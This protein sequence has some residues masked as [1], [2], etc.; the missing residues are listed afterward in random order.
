MKIM[1][2]KNFGIFIV[3]EAR[4]TSKRLKR[5]HLYKFQGVTLIKLLV[6]KL[7]KVKKIN[8]IILATTK[9]KIENVLIKDLENEKIKIF[10]GSET[11]VLQRVIN[12]GKKFKA[13]A[14]CRI[15]GDCPLIDI[16]FVQELV[17]VYI[18]EKTNGIEFISNSK[19][20]PIGQG[21]SI[22]KLQTLEKIYKQTNLARHKEFITSYIWENKKNFQQL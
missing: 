12:A 10:R 3:I 16:R 13:E 8:G 22:V 7:K 19:G 11:N 5:K 15:T 18:K 14:I 17:D 20:L 4:S 2:K 9:N 1:K 21:G 6:K